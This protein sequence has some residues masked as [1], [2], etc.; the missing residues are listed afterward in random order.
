MCSLRWTPKIAEAFGSP[1]SSLGLRSHPETGAKAARFVA[2]VCQLAVRFSLDDE[3]RLL[4]ERVT[5]GASIAS[6]ASDLG[7]SPRS[8]YR[9]L[10]RLWEGL[11]VLNRAAGVRKALQ[12][13]LI[14]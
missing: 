5:A 2:G 13:G 7:Y 14:G 4:L 1:H 12:Q 8:I 9:A 3:Q 6:L 10:S 11:G